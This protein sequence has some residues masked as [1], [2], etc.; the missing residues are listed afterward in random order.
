MTTNDPNIPDDPHE[1]AAHWF[2]RDHGGLMTP[3]ERVVFEAWRKADPRHE[4]A[5]QAMMT[6]WGVAKAT[7][8]RVFE[9]IL[10]R[11]AQ[12]AVAGFSSRRRMLALGAGTA[13]VAV[14]ATVVAG[15]ERWFHAP[16]YSGRYVSP[17]GERRIVDLPDGS[18][19]TLN[20]G[21]IAQVRFYESERRVLLEQGEAFFSVAS[22]VN[23]PFVVDAGVAT[24]TVTGT[25]FNVRR[26]AGQ[27]SV[28]VESGSVEVAGGKWWNRKVRRL[29]AAQSVQVASSAAVSEVSKA[30]IEML[31][32][33]RQGKVIFNAA[34]LATIVAEMNRYRAQPVR[35]QS[36]ALQGLR[37][38]GVFNTDDPD[39][40]LDVLPSLAPV[41]VRRLPDGRSEIVPR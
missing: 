1:A 36:A 28:A 12:P 40:F 15:P 13:C 19:L 31:T 8:D 25:R 35:L 10:R 30:N 29:S 37:V 34:P 7:P 2:A 24:V 11:P 41:M 32:A 9:N 38:A 23:H 22:A 5:Y 20:T 17:R 27:V 4:Q 3:D 16:A 39:A 6:V 18:A 26:D 14:L 21:S 33:W